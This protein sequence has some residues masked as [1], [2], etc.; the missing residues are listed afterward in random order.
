M[1]KHFMQ[2]GGPDKGGVCPYG[3][4]CHFAHGQA[5]LRSPDPLKR[6][7]IDSLKSSGAKPGGGLLRALLSKIQKE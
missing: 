7:A 6:R 1:C 5:D 4:D 3:D 2:T